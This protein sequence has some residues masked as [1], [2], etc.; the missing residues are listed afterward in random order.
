VQKDGGL[1]HNPSFITTEADGI[2]AVVE[3]L[4]H[5]AGKKD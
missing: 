5:E 1:A 3:A 2:K 4:V